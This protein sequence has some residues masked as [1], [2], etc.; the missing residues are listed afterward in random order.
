MTAKTSCAVDGC[1]KPVACLC[2]HCKENVC[3]KH[4]N[5]H[6]TQVLNELGP[7]SDRL[8]E[9]KMLLCDTEA[10]NGPLIELKIWREERYKE[11]DRKYNEKVKE[12]ERKLGKQ[13]EEVS[14]L[15]TRIGELTNEG[16]VSFDQVE[17]LKGEIERV[18]NQVHLL[19][20]GERRNIPSG[21]T[22][23]DRVLL[24]TY[25]QLGHSKCLIKDKVSCAGEDFYAMESDMSLTGYDGVCPRCGKS[26]T[27]LKKGRGFYVSCQT[28]HERLTKISNSE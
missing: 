1:K 3:S 5:E 21:N 19:T 10:A 6:Q 8:N 18:T 27:P 22:T 20:T 28:L 7:L 15:M 26:H 11:I 13:D 12:Y 25:V 17:Q 2:H 4:F 14:K 9:L 24:N 16:D 23:T